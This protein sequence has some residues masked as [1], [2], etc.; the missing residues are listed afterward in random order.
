MYAAE[1]IMAVTELVRSD[2]EARA[3]AESLSPTGHAATAQRVSVSGEHNLVIIA[4]RDIRGLDVQ[5]SS[6]S[7][8][9]TVTRATGEISKEQDKHLAQLRQLRQ[10]LATRLDQGELRTLCFD[11]GI[12]YD[13]LPGEGKANKARELVAYLDN[14][15]R[16]PELLRAGEQLRPDISWSDTH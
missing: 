2:P 9:E 14:R 1:I 11:L 15:G 10:L 8:E 12:D 4:G 6:E 16:I 5:V 7:R 13:D 3:L